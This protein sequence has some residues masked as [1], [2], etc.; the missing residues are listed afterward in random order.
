LFEDTDGD[1]GEFDL[2]ELGGDTGDLGLVGAVGDEEVCLSFLMALVTAA[3]IIAVVVTFLTIVLASGLA[4]ELITF[5]A[6]CRAI[7][8]RATLARLEAINP[9]IGI[10]GS[11]ICY[12]SL[13]YTLM[14]GPSTDFL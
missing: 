2:G 9:N 11:G 13:K 14:S 5:G 4:A 1:D 8:G 12:T 6:S 10:S 3:P 7:A